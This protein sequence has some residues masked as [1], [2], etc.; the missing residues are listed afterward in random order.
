[1]LYIVP[2]HGELDVS[3]VTNNASEL[4]KR[5]TCENCQ[6]SMP[7]YLLS[8]HTDI[9]TGGIDKDIDVSDCLYIIHSMN[10]EGPFLFVNLFV[11]L[12][13]LQDEYEDSDIDVYNSSYDGTDTDPSPSYISTDDVSTPSVTLTEKLSVFPSCL[14]TM[15]LLM[16]VSFMGP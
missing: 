4:S 15:L 1:M 10:L 16:V 3:P 11:W 14:I 8:I 12:T 2:S 5:T 7:R 9:C 6:E 13:S